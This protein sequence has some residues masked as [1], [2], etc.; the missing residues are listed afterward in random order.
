METAITAPP[1]NFLPS[2][3]V[4]S[5]LL[6]RYPPGVAFVK[7][8][9][10]I[11][12]AQVA[13]VI[14]AAK[15]GLEQSPTDAEVAPREYRGQP[16]DFGARPLTAGK[17]SFKI[18]GSPRFVLYFFGSANAR[19]PPGPGGSCLALLVSGHQRHEYRVLEYV[20]GVAAGHLANLA[21]EAIFQLR[22]AVVAKRQDGLA[23]GRVD[24]GDGSGIG[25][26]QTPV[27]AL[28]ICNP[29]CRSAAL[30]LPDFLTRCCIQRHH[31]VLRPDIHGSVDDHRTEGR[32]VPD[33]YL[34]AT[35]SCFTLFLWI[36]LSEEYCEWSAPPPMASQVVKLGALSSAAAAARISAAA[37][38]AARKIRMP[39]K[40]TSRGTG[41]QP[42]LCV[43]CRR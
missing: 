6:T 17:S 10:D 25:E 2:L 33:S 30:V 13:E 27:L 4:Q 39:C 40:Y 1:G 42:V 43:T 5:R 28:P 11:D 29:A 3:L 24:R 31:G 20:P 38:T 12:F 16:A 18:G 22:A 37:I 36:C 19:Y 14:D 34:Q 32:I 26:K 9:N 15:A 35:S 23:G 21:V 7:G 8:E 41:L